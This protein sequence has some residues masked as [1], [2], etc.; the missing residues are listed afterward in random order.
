MS[1]QFLAFLLMS[2]LVSYGHRPPRTPPKRDQ[3]STV[4]LNKTLDEV[5]FAGED[6]NDALADL[7]E[8]SG[9]NLVVD[10]PALEAIGIYGDTHVDLSLKNVSVAA[11]LDSVLLLADHH[12]LGAAFIIRDGLLI[13]TSK[14]VLN[15]HLEVRAYECP[16]SLE[17]ATMEWKH[18]RAGSTTAPWRPAPRVGSLRWKKVMR[19][20]GLPPYIG[21]AEAI[22]ATVDPDSWERRG[23]P[24]SIRALGD[25][26]IIR[27]SQANH[28]AIERLLDDLVD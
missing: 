5:R 14:A 9:F 4:R 23:G 2:S 13:I 22:Q 21:L 16:A 18:P 15:R 3:A 24:G 25:K 17:S 1:A 26:L 28:A 10:W 19:A 8:E 11:A 27:Q 7:A 20:R 12:H 6:L